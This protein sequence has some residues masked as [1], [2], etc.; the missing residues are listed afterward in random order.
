[1]NSPIIVAVEQQRLTGSG[2]GLPTS[3][4]SLR[5]RG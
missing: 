1:M 3:G 2:N 5:D 4:W